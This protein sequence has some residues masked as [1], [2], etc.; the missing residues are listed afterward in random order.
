MEGLLQS[1]KF[2][3]PAEQLEVC[4]P[5]GHRAKQ[6]GN[7]QPWCEAHTLH[8]DGELIDRSSEC[9]ESLLYEAYSQLYVTNQ[10]ARDALLATEDAAATHVVGGKDSPRTILTVHEFCSRLTNIRNELRI[11]Q[12]VQFAE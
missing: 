12:M 4:S 5:F 3:D 10:S 7:Y 1:L 2:Q 9:Y 11:R 6:L 8:W